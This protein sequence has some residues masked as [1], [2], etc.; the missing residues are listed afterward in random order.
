MAARPGNRRDPSGLQGPKSFEHNVVLLQVARLLQDTGLGPEFVPAG[1]GRTPDLIL[2]ISATRWLQVDTK[3]PRA[4]QAPV[5]GETVRLI[6]PRETIGKALRRMRGQFSGPGSPSS[7]E[8]FGSTSSTANGRGIDAYADAAEKFLNEAI[9]AD[10]SKEAITHY[11]RLLGILFASVGWNV[12]GQTYRQS[13]H[14]RW[15]PN[16]R[17]A[18]IIEFS[19]PRNVDG[20]F[21]M[22]LGR[23]V[24]SGER[25]IT[26]AESSP[27]PV[28][29]EGNEI[30][31]PA[32]FALTNTG[33]VVAEGSIT[34]TRRS[35][36]RTAVFRF[37][38]GYR[39]THRVYFDVMCDGGFTV[40]TV[41]P[42]GT[43]LADPSAGWI[44][45]HGVRFEA[46]PA[47]PSN[48]T[49][50]FAGRASSAESGRPT[51]TLPARRPSVWIP[52]G[53]GCLAHPRARCSFL[54]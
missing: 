10:A 52:L 16:P 41:D 51:R 46:A 34:A 28:D 8:I 37:P 5:E 24:D 36:S 22:S 9:P 35:D 11:Q 27:P 15:V 54:R 13:L 19:L 23:V 17:Y 33:Y 40:V 4:I 12:E 26:P 18:D 30:F 32:R 50:T 49:R 2:R 14:L 45:L 44:R 31:D 25:L 39:P 48:G 3:T 53:S 29:N 42:D 7:L 6:S 1:G 21:N 38:K 43:F 47:G 20:P